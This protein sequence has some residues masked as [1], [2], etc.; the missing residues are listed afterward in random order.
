MWGFGDFSG[1]HQT[2]RGVSFLN[3]GK[4]AGKEFVGICVRGCGN[5]VCVNIRLLLSNGKEGRCKCGEREDLFPVKLCDF[6]IEFYP[7]EI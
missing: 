4:D 3:D 2:H 1:V 5:G 7:L 6:L